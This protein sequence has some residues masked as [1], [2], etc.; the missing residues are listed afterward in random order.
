VAPI[1]RRLK[2][3]KE[4]AA[5]QAAVAAYDGPVTRCPPGVARAHE[6]K[7]RYEPPKKPDGSGAHL[8]ELSIL[9]GSK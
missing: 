4:M 5:M 1:W 7:F 9:K 3:T 6:E 8:A 2:N